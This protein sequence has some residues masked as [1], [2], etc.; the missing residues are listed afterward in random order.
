MDS[1]ESPGECKAPAG[2]SKIIFCHFREEVRGRFSIQIARP[3][4][5]ISA[6]LLGG[7]FGE[8]VAKAVARADDRHRAGRSDDCFVCTGQIREVP[9]AFA[10][11]LPLRPKPRLGMV[12]PICPRC[13]AKDEAEIVAR[14]VSVLRHIWPGLRARPTGAEEGRA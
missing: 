2:A 1:N 10:V 11:V 5:L 6:L 3:E 9:L 7:P 4:H 14:L 13:E 8:A 12:L